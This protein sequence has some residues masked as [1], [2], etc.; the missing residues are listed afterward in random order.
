MTRHTE[1]AG[2]VERGDG[3]DVVRIAG[4]TVGAGQPCFVIAEAGVNHNG[5]VETA[6]RL[7]DAAKQAGA[8]AVKFQ[9]FKSE[10]VISASAPKAAYQVRTTGAR[11]SQLEMVKKLELPPAAFHSLA[12][13]CKEQE[14]MFLSTPFDFGSVELLEEIGVPA[15]K[16][17][18]GEITNFPLLERVARTG[19]PIILST[20]MS[21]LA[22]VASAL[23]TM[24]AACGPEIILLHCTS[25]Y[26]ASASSANLRA[27]KTMAESFSVPVGLSDHTE[28]ISIAIAAVA[29]G[30]CVLEKHLTLDRTLP[31]PDHRASLEGNEFAEMVRSIRR[32]EEALGDGVK[33]PAPEEIGTSAVARRS[34][35]AR[36]DISEGTFITEQMIAIRRPGTGLPPRMY[37]A[38]I[39]RRMKMRVSAG[40]VLTMDM[41]E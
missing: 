27:M 10:E 28:G 3:T 1:T 15:F 40:T 5:D 26:P 11:E 38:L 29:L 30:A 20:G 35:V 33:K 19:K 21:M 31:G 34:L 39:G 18:S 7:I 37:S 36:E 14:I 22:E 41:I 25:N 4:H 17:G 13:H 23:E 32:V 6:L 16:I 2:P 24:R 9:T 8:D 12:K